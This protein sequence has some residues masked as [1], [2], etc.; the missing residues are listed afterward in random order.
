MYAHA[1]KKVDPRSVG[2]YTF[3]ILYLSFPVAYNDIFFQPSQV[4]TT[5]REDLFFK[6]KQYGYMT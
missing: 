3:A 6:N 1:R 5:I 2:D 4:R